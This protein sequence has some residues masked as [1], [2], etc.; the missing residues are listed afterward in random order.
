MIVEGVTHSVDQNGHF[1]K[2]TRDQAVEWHHPVASEQ[3]VSVDIKVAA[4]IAID[5]SAKRF[6]HLRL[7]EPFADPSKLSV[8]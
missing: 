2:D 6:H 7:I 5:L 4:L 8:A 1:L 3:E